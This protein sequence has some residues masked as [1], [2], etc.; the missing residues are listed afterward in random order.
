MTTNEATEKALKDF[1]NDPL[2]Q[3][4]ILVASGLLRAGDPSLRNHF[5]AI[6]TAEA[7]LGKDHILAKT[8]S[9]PKGQTP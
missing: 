9:Q 4:A 5:S 3:Q 7:K 2:M 8:R 6:L 1:Q